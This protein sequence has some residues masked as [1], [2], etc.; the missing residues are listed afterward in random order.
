[1]KKIK[2]NLELI[3]YLIIIIILTIIMFWAINK[4]EGFHEDE[5]F[6]YGVSNSTLGNTFLS[7]GRIDIPDSIIKSRNPFIMLKN[8]IYYKVIKP[9]AYNLAVKELNID[10]SKSIWRTRGDAIEYLQIDNWKEAIDFMSIYWNTAKD[11]HPPL[12]YIA[13]HIASI[14]FWGHFSKYIIFIVNLV[15]FIGTLWYL[16]KIIIL[17]NRKELSIPNIILYESITKVVNTLPVPSKGII[18]IKANTIPI[19]IN[20]FNLLP[21]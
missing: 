10:I 13:V 12:F 17:I 8:Y 15:F 1:M 9:E 21:K 11:V 3:L 4:K 18:I 5:M 20:H 6:S 14:L 16:R 19:A 7:Y 2:N